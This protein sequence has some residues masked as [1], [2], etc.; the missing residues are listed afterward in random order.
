[1]RKSV[2]DGLTSLRVS[3][4]LSAMA[5]L[6]AD[7][8]AAVFTVDNSADVG[9]GSLR[10]A[11]LEANL[12][13]GEDTIFVN[14]ALNGATIELFAPL[15][16]LT[17]KVAINNPGRLTIRYVSLN[18]IFSG[19]YPIVKENIGTLIFSGTNSYSGGTTINAGAVQGD[20]WSL[21]GDIVNQSTVIFDQNSGDGI[22]AGN[23][24]GNGALIKVGGRKLTLTGVNSY[25]GGT[26]INEGLLEGDTD[27]LRGNV[28][29]N[30]ALIFDQAFKG[31]FAG[32]VSGTGSLTKFGPGTLILTGSNTYTGMTIV[33]EGVLQGNTRSLPT[34]IVNGSTVIFDQPFDGVYGGKI[35]YAGTVIKE[36]A[37]TLT[38]TGANSYTGRTVVNQ[39]ALRGNSI[40]LQGNIINNSAV[41]FDQATDGTY[42]ASLSG[43]GALT[44]AGR[45]S[46][47]LTSSNAFAGPTTVLDGRLS[48]FLPFNSSVNILG[49]TF[50]PAG[51]TAWVTP[52]LQLGGPPAAPTGSLDVGSGAVIVNFPAGGSDPSS[53]V[54][55]QIIAGRGGV[56]IV[57]DWSGR[58]I[59]SS[60]AAATNR[61]SAGARSVAYANNGK[62]PLGPYFSYRGSSLDDTSIL[63]T[64]TRTGDANLDGVV[65]DADVTIVS[66][67][68]APGISQPFWS[69]GDFDYNGFVDDDDVTLLN[70]FYDP[71]ALPFA[72][73]DSLSAQ[74]SGLLT[75][76]ASV[77]EPA[78]CLLVAAAAVAALGMEARKRCVAPR[79]KTAT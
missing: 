48:V 8:A 60:A 20:S 17:E 5:L 57:G 73:T 51:S 15:P 52:S 74:T 62:L 34:N 26:V 38:L 16:A 59:T 43:S 7:L 44:K 67:T 55:Q 37:G 24:T 66:A 54:R 53:I 76:V 50:A 29:N 71:L 69:Y 3:L 49:G 28:A 33:S 21:K 58:G 4:V 78:G 39:G 30:S 23:I 40:S 35:N 47:T 9:L 25:A 2:S 12:H 65:N 56:S 22:Y 32:N 63:I 64:F 45:G 19:G 79:K 1:M 18:H 11:V 10:Q 14:P 42:S 36:G 72:Q 61:N 13:P 75:P 70:A 68:Y 27:S 41:I 31:T 77:P 6:Q 46:L